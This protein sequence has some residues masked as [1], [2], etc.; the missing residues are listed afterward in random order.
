MELKKGKMSSG[1]SLLS[2]TDKENCL[3]FFRL[4]CYNCQCK[5]DTESINKTVHSYKESSCDSM[6]FNLPPH[7]SF[8]LKICAILLFFVIF[9]PVRPLK[10]KQKRTQNFSVLLVQQKKKKINQS[11]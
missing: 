10:E 7:V 9:G 3:V 8:S 6:T 4:T 11:I 5:C 2:N 1:C